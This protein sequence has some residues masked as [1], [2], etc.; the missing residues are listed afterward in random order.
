M[1]DT[2]V[3]DREVQTRGYSLIRGLITKVEL[4]ELS[5]AAESL[6][7]TG[8]NRRSGPLYAIRNALGAHPSFRQVAASGP[9]RSRFNRGGATQ[10]AGIAH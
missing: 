6:A 1:Y 10:T 3:I 2:E 8:S 4:D 5:Q 9:I 7:A